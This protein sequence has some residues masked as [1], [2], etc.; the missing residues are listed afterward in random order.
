ME[1]LEEVLG[2]PKVCGDKV[3]Y[4]YPSSKKL[5]ACYGSAVHSKVTSP[6]ASATKKFFP[7]KRTPSPTPLPTKRD[8]GKPPI[9]LRICR[10]KSRLLSDSDESESTLTPST[11]VCSST[12]TS[13]SARDSQPSPGHSRVTRSTSKSLQDSGLSPATAET[14][15]ETFSALLS[16]EYIPPEKF[17]LERKAMYDN[18]LGPSSPK[19][20][21]ISSTFTSQETEQKVVESETCME[22][23]DTSEQNSQQ[24]D[25]MELEPE[26]EVYTNSSGVFSQDSENILKYDQPQEELEESVLIEQPSQNAETEELIKSTNMEYN[27]TEPPI[28][29]E[30]KKN[31]AMTDTSSEEDSDSSQHPPPSPI[32]DTA[33]STTLTIDQHRDEILE[34]ILEKP[35][36]APVVKLVISKKKGSIFKSR[37]MVPDT[38]GGKKRRA[39]Y[40]HK[41]CDEKDSAQVTF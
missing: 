5:K 11:V 37:S 23:M 41:W 40:K 13:P 34:K 35:I 1:P 39:L 24:S 7:S 27:L 12:I 2:D 36:E 15:A 30:P 22:S 14:P 8:D 38:D 28:D 20:S 4:P 3:D 33:T 32:H 9:V 17:E 26:S 29:T 16:P 31:E 10:G 21:V 25:D 19:D 6:R 18:L